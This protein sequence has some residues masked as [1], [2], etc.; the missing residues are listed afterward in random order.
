[1]V[2]AEQLARAYLARFPHEF[3]PLPDSGR[4]Y[5]KA[6]HERIC[7]NWLDRLPDCLAMSNWAGKMSRAYCDVL[8]VKFPRTKPQLVEIVNDSSGPDSPTAKKSD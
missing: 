8:G 1:M 4:E 3:A 6:D 2:T 7:Q 5:D